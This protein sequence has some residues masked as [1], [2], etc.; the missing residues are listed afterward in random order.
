VPV[1]SKRY[2]AKRFLV[3]V[4]KP[5]WLLH[6]VPWPTMKQALFLLTLQVK[7]KVS[8]DYSQLL[9]LRHGFAT[10][11][12]C[13]IRWSYNWGIRKFWL[14]WFQPILLF[15]FCNHEVVTLYHVR[16]CRTANTLGHTCCFTALER[17]HCHYVLEWEFARF[18]FR[19]QIMTP[20]WMQAEGS[21]ISHYRTADKAFFLS[22]LERRIWT[23][24]IFKDSSVRTAQETHFFSIIKASHWLIYW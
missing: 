15:T 11:D 3:C 16:V 21:K 24:I 13:T 17:C 18:S 14:R 7:A 12:A 6:V 20:G 8:L 4:F 5:C 1:G 9:T 22:A 19:W 23:W 2:I 10:R